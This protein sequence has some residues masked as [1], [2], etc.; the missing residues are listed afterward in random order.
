MF[1]GNFVTKPRTNQ[2]HQVGKYNTFNQFDPTTSERDGP[3]STSNH[4]IGTT[5]S[6]GSNVF[7]MVNQAKKTPN[8]NQM[9]MT[10]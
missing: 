1:N 9:M 4:R 2:P 6:D 3:S 10:G 5:N 8:T 7:T